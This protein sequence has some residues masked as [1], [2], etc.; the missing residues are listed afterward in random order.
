MNSIAAE[1]A[2]TIEIREGLC[3]GGWEEK[4]ETQR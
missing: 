2:E 4:E 3:G 1:D